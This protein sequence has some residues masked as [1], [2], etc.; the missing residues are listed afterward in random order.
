ME[1]AP[2]AAKDLLRWSEALSAIARTGLGFTQSLYEKER[3]EEILK[4]AADIRVGAGHELEAEVLVEEWL[5][6]VGDGV[7]GYVTPKV[8]VGAV[9]GN[10]KGEILLVQRADSGVWLYPTGWADVG[11]SASEVAVKEVS[12]ETGIQCEPQR[13][14]AV[15]DGLRLGFTRVPLYSLVFQCRMVGGSLEAHPLE[16]A[17]VGWFPEE[18]LPSPLAGADRWAR[19]AFAA[20]R[21]ER[22]D[23]LFDAPRHPPWRR[24]Q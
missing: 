21:G 20:L 3:F 22:V 7:A 24:D 14:I 8:A 12:E 10:A 1:E 11:Y 9:V 16:C 18:G 4:V 17:D 15:L 2:V 19:H 23:V 6:G 5:R 13:L